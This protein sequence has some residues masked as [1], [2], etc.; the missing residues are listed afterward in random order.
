[1][2]VTGVTPDGPD[3]FCSPTP[4]ARSVVQPAARRARPGETRSIDVFLDTGPLF[5]A[6]NFGFL[7]CAELDA[8]WYD[9]ACDEGGTDITVTKTAPAACDPGAD[10][11]F[12]VTITNGGAFPFS[13]PV[14]FTDAMFLPGGAALLPPITGIVPALGCAPAPGGLAFSCTAVLTLAPGG[15]KAFAITVTMPAVPPAYWA[16]NCFA[17]S[18][19]GAVP[20]AL[21]LAPGAHS[22][23]VSCAWVPVGGP[24]PLVNLRLEKTALHGGACYKVGP[25]TIACDYE[26]EIINDGPS[27]HMGAITF[28]DDIPAAAALSAFPAPWVCVGAHPTTCGS[29]IAVAIP[30]DG[31]VTVPVTATIPLAPL[32]G[33]GCTLPN[34]ATI[35]APAGGTPWNFFA[36]DD[37]DMAVADAWLE[38]WTPAGI[39]ATC[40]PT[41][42][43]VKKVAKGDCVA[44]DGGYRCDYAV[45]VTN[46]GPDPYKGTLKILEQF[47]FAPSSVK[48]SPG[49]GRVGGG[50]NYKLTLPDVDL[51]KGESVEL[52]VSA[53]VPD[54]P[55]CEL[56]NT[57]IMTNPPANTRF[58]KEPSD[59]ADS[60][61]AKIPSKSCVK[62]DRPQCKPGPNEFRSESGACVCKSGTVRNESGLCVGLT[63]PPVTEPKLC[64]DGKPVPK[65]GRC[66]STPPQC[67]P[68]PNEQRNAKGQCV[69][70]DGFERDDRG[71]CIEI[72][73][74]HPKDECEDRGLVWNEN[75][76]SCVPPITPPIE[77]VPYK[78]EVRDRHGECVCRKGYERDDRGRCIEEEH[79]GDECE[80]K[81]WVWDDKRDRCVPPPTE[82]P[83]C[84]PGK[85]EERRHGQ[86]VCKQGY[87]RN[88]HGYCVA[89]RPQCEPGP[90]EQRNEKGQCVCK[91]GYD[92]NK[93]GHCVAPPSPPEECKDKGWIWDGKRCLSPADACKLKGWN[94][95]DGRCLA[96]T[97]PADECRK[98]SG[99]WDGKRKRCLT[100]EDL[101]KAK[102]GNWDGNTCQPKANPADE[103]RKTG[104]SWDGKRKRCLTQEDLCKVKGG[105]WDGNTCQPKTNP[106]NECRKTG[107]TWDGKRKRCLTPEDL[108]KVKGGNWDGNTCQPKTNPANECRKT[109]GT[110][111]GKRKRCLSQEDLCKVKGGAWDGNTCQRPGASAVPQANPAEDCRTKG[112]KWDSKRCRLPN[113]SIVPRL[114][115]PR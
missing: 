68:G 59:D 108:C 2:I 112:G 10:C 21:P 20:P 111:D 98:T 89:S 58:N 29:A 71:R 39:F 13:G 34:T 56:K 40:D 110:W 96:P 27:P 50:A 80:D 70:L 45:T 60:A 11:T 43:K 95:D 79:P 16:Q 32:E 62:P 76:E 100:P 63:E 107:G 64:P 26:I 90:N 99:T 85:N 37:S 28:T 91:K 97:N 9:V 66:P 75:T 65:N 114:N 84:V 42:L 44:S 83:I 31:S 61:T 49:W 38:W 36:G 115:I 55:H 33:A 48:F 24:P 106:A 102:G 30:V 101:C 15:S 88:D 72:E 78:N 77:C 12:T 81:G 18:A 54:G 1:M 104:G 92:R 109:G 53:I 105:N 74:E 94:W 23:T 17:V 6:G 47:G 93:D 3:W 25:A 57:A 8:P 4:D 5:A 46:M 87:E 35:T 51:D 113:P 67:Q 19:P 69:C 14:Q 73:E 86:C 82:P 7:N 103:C 41:N 52:S 22:N